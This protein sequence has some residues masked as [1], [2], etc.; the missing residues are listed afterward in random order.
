M[1]SYV[2][3]GS[4]DRRAAKEFYDAALAPLGLKPGYS[5]DEMVG[6]GPEG[7]ETQL[8]VV[9]PFNGL[10]ATAGNG[11]MLALAARPDLSEL[12]RNWARLLQ[13]ASLSQV[14][15]LFSSRQPWSR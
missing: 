15:P 11:T 13:A 9:Q 8:W 3:L 4:T 12:S 7:G 10:D 1:I 6:Y 5:D 14:Q 2:T